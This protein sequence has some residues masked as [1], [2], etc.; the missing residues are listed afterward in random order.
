LRGSGAVKTRLLEIV[1]VRPEKLHPEG[2]KE[3]VVMVGIIHLP[4]QGVMVSRRI[5]PFFRESYY[6]LKT[7]RDRVIAQ[8]VYIIEKSDIFRG[9]RHGVEVAVGSTGFYCRVQQNFRIFCLQI[10]RTG[11]A[12]IVNYGVPD[13]IMGHKEHVRPYPGGPVQ[14]NLSPA[15]N[16]T[17]IFKSYLHIGIMPVESGDDG[18]GPVLIVH[19]DQKRPANAPFR[20]FLR[21]QF[22][23]GPAP[24][25]TDDHG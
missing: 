24:S 2:G 21:F 5:V 14:R 20:A 16:I 19:P 23:V 22:P 18:F 4:A 11:E 6:F 1:H 17:H 9:N 12:N 25:P 8:K 7:F 15:V 13:M 3:E 10:R